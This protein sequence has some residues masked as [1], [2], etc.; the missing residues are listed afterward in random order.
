MGGGV[1]RTRSRRQ[2]AIEQ[3]GNRAAMHLAAAV[4]LGRLKAHAHLR[5][6]VANALAA[7]RHG[8]GHGHGQAKEHVG[9]FACEGAGGYVVVGS[10]LVLHGVDCQLFMAGPHGAGRRAT[11][12]VNPLWRPWT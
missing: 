1:V 2:G 10:G 11:G 12:G 8:A 5:P 4:G 7:Q 6:V 9:G 3:R